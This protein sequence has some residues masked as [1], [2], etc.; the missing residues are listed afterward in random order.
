MRL[1]NFRI[2]ATGKPSGGNH[3]EEHP[4]SLKVPGPVCSRLRGWLT[5]WLIVS[6]GSEHKHIIK[7]IRL[8]PIQASK[9]LYDA[10]KKDC[11]IIFKG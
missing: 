8:R 10:R 7:W 11:S 4:P 2:L 9:T 5:C 6:C 3:K 1:E